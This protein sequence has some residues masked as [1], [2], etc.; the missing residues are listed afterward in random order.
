MW[1]SGLFCD[2]TW[3]PLAA[4][5]LHFVWQG[6]VVAAAWKVLFRCFRDCRS[7]TQYLLGLAGLLALTACPIGTFALLK[8][9][10]EA[11]RVRPIPVGAVEW[12]ASN[13]DDVCA[14]PVRIPKVMAA[15]AQPAHWQD[16]IQQWADAGQPYLIAGWMAGLTI[17]SGR[18]LFGFVGARRLR[19]GRRPVSA[20][21]ADRVAVLAGRLGLRMVPGVF[22]SDVVRDAVVTGLL[23][24]MVLLPAAWLLEMT[25]ELL[26]AVIAHELA[27]IRR[28]DLWVNLFQRLVETILFYHPAV[29]WL[30]H[31]VRLVREMCCDE[32][33]VAAT[34]ERVVYAT[35]LE[36]AAQ[37][38]LAPAKPLLAVA[39]G[40]TRM[41]LLSRVRNVLGLPDGEKK[42]RW[43]PTILLGL[44]V[45]L[46]VC[47]AIVLVGRGKYVATTYLRV[48]MQEKPIAFPTESQA[49]DRDRFEI[50]KSTQQQLV[51]S[52]FVLMAALRRPEVAKLPS[53]QEAQKTATP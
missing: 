2:P 47:V 35:A 16:A 15:A 17:L 28:F 25:P 10:A 39:L 33:A 8:S 36:F 3:R 42:G 26:E 43:W 22:V 38:R 41:T 50:Y 31:R 34:G 48:A 1:P 44:L 32:L 13:S 7:Q 27:H 11:D 52:R 29:W 9:N 18:L 12:Q 45:L 19:R 23:R 21:L 49:V 20:A 24:P 46:V 37:R 30:S 6:L 14:V 53:V 4:T 5:L 40:A 51:M